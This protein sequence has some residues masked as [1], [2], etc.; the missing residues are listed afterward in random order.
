[1]KTLWS[2][3]LFIS[4]FLQLNAQQPEQYVL[5]TKH[6]IDSKILQENREF[7]VHVPEVTETYS[8]FPVVYLFDAA[9]N[10]TLTKGVL[11]NLQ[12]SEVLPPVILVGILNKGFDREY[13]LSPSD[14]K[15]DYMKTGGGEKFLSFLKNELTV[16]IEENFPATSHRSVI[17]HS[18]GALFNLFALNEAPELFHNY[19]NISPSLWWEKGA[20]ADKIK[21]EIAQKIF[22]SEKRVFMTMANEAAVNGPNGKLMNEKYI[23]LSDYFNGLRLHNLNVKRKNLYED[24]HITAVTRATYFGLSYLFE[25]WNTDSFYEQGDF[26]GL[27]EKLNQLSVKYGLEVPPSYAVVNIGRSAHNKG[28]Y[29]LAIKIYQYGLK[30]YPEGLQMNAFLGDALDGKGDLKNA[31]ETFEKTLVI[32]QRTDSPMISWLEGRLASVNQKIKK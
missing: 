24:N 27:K 5:A 18:I 11:E 14:I 1:M 32:A 15:V 13:N 20:Y 16:Y 19:L 31:K 12:R 6:S 8:K 17:G 21:R 9:H 4:V 29:D 26:D 10:F 25:D 28:E 23:E 7:W 3:V 30:Y 2:T 22:S